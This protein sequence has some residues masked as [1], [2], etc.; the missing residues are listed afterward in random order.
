MTSIESLNLKETSKDSLENTFVK[1]TL[2]STTNYAENVSD[3]LNNSDEI[4]CIIEPVTLNLVT[5][6]D[7]ENIINN[8]SAALR[9]ESQV[10]ETE[11]ILKSHIDLKVNFFSD[12]LHL[13]SNKIF[14]YYQM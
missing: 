14:F 3:N 4:N 11:T 7:E 5:N 9:N 10:V 13:S 8:V 6:N 2:E 1:H 12:W